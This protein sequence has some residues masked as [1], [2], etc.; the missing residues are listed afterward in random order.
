MVWQ[1]PGRGELSWLRAAHRSLSQSGISGQDR[2]DAVCKQSAQPWESCGSMSR[3][4][5]TRC[6]LTLS[7]F[8]LTR[9][10]CFPISTNQP[11]TS[12]PKEPTNHKYKK[13]PGAK[14]VPGRMPDAPLGKKLNCS[15][16]AVMETS[17]YQAERQQYLDGVMA[18]VLVP[19]N[20]NVLQRLCCRDDK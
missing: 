3:G 15:P 12:S 11:L 20:E 10:M 6:P 19:S 14:D 13:I 8:K 1:C 5:L 2:A 7:P 18:G 4:G 17:H 16:N 9:E